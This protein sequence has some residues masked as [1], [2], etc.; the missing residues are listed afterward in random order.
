MSLSLTQ[1]QQQNPF[2]FVLAGFVEGV[3][4]PHWPFTV[5][6]ACRL[7]AVECLRVQASDRPSVCLLLW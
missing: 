1:Q 2:F 4:L 7:L 5:S 6:P 3:E